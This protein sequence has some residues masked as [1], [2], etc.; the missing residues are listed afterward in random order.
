MLAFGVVALVRADLI[1]DIFDYMPQLTYY[2]AKAGFDLQAT[3]Y[4]SAIFMVV[5]G[6]IVGGVGVLGCA[7]ACLNVQWM[8]S[9]VSHRFYVLQCQCTVSVTLLHFTSMQSFYNVLQF[10]F[11]RYRPSSQN[12]LCPYLTN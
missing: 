9:L 11:H 2:T 1:A 4:N 10:S 5:L 7:G 8:L 3:V 6:G 12:S